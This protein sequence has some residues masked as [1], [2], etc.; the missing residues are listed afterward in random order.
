MRLAVIV[1]IRSLT[2]S[3]T[4]QVTTFRVMTSLT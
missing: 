2:E 1:D 4:E 3:P